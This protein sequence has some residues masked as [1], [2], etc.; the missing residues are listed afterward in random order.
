MSIEDGASSL[1][2]GRGS[3]RPHTTFTLYNNN[4]T[5]GALFVALPKNAPSD[6]ASG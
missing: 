1:I 4:K 3:D 2:E 6:S 5:K